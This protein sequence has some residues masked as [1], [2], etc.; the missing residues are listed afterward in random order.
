[1][2]VGS[3]TGQKSARSFEQLESHVLSLQDGDS[4]QDG[5]QPTGRRPTHAADS[6][7]S[8]GISSRR[9]E[10]DDDDDKP[11]GY[12]NE[13]RAVDDKGTDSTEVTGSGIAEATSEK[14]K[15]LEQ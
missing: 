12:N 3:A 2:K 4:I 11:S 8:Y 6:L 7:S 10:D 1:M 5:E 13:D 9:Q 14:P 15:G